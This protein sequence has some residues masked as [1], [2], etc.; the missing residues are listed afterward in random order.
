MAWRSLQL[1]LPALDATPAART[2]APLKRQLYE[3]L[4]LAILDGRL[5]P[6]ARMPSSRELARELGVS[7]NTAIAACELLQR[8]GYLETRRG[9]GSY[10]SST[11]PERFLNQPQGTP[12]RRSRSLRRP[13]PLSRRGQQLAEQSGPFPPD[14]SGPFHLGPDWSAF[15]F[16]LWARSLGRVWRNPPRGQVLGSDPGGFPPLQSWIADFLATT[17][18]V[19]AEPEQVMVVSGSQQAL[20]LVTRLT[21]DPGDPVLVEDPCWPGIAGTLTGSGAEPVFVPVDDY[22]FDVARAEAL[23]PEARVAFVTPSHQYPLGMTMPLERR[24]ALLDWAIRKRGFVVEDDYDSDFRYSGTPVASLQGLDATSAGGQ[25]LYL[26][27]FSKLLF[28]SLR[29]GYLVVPPAL[30]D[31]CHRAR[32]VL[33]GHASLVTQ[34]ALADFAEAGHLTSHLRSMRELYAERRE[35]LL[36]ALHRH[37]AGALTP[38]PEEGGMHLYVELAAGLSDVDIVERAAR[39]GIEA[40]ALS[41]YCRGQARNALF[42]G[43][44]AHRPEKLRWAVRRLAAA[45]EGA[46]QP[47]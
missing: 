11:L 47:R 9:S 37:L 31:A 6:G 26:G 7:R 10:V 1:L 30:V 39:L 35:V 45:V 17:R 42:L 41:R 24:L 13:P 21:L 4:R 19:Q 40:R 27:T 43:F 23:C 18:S 15:P 22:G 25:V 16:P 5:K 8:E 12:G 2:G 33:D 14:P 34:V 29:L 32:R 38:K 36:G 3:V 28:P 44:A 20:D 46:H